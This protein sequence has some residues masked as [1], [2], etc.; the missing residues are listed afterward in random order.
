MKKEIASRLVKALRSGEYNQ[1]IGALRRETSGE[2]LYCCLG[3]LCSLD[4]KVTWSR[5]TVN[6]TRWVANEVCKSFLPHSTIKWAGMNL[7]GERELA[8]MNDIG[9]SFNEIADYIEKNWKAL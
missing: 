7:A 3:V 8:R 6:N 9:D 1:G 4:E 5:S 2:D